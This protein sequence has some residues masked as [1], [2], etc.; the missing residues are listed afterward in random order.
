MDFTGTFI[1]N[2]TD[3]L[4]GTINKNILSAFEPLMNK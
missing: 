3:A 2:Y 1:Y 4:T